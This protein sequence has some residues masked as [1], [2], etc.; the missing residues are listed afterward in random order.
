MNSTG[1]EFKSFYS[2]QAHLRCK[3]NSQLSQCKG[4]ESDNFYNFQEGCDEWNT[5]K[6]A[7]W[8]LHL[9][10]DKKKKLKKLEHK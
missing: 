9:D 5:Y 8:I 1:K 3:K 7:Q 4:L 6:F 2:R 10:H